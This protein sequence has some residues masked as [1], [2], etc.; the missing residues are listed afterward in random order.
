MAFGIA[1]PMPSPVRAR[2]AGERF[3]RLRSG[4]QQRAHAEDQHA[5][6]EHRPAA[7]LVGKRTA[8]HRADHH[9]HE[10]TGDDRPEHAARDLHRR[11]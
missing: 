6:D 11:R 5:S 10:A 7:E 9:P 2:N 3:D 1:P 8:H 4:R